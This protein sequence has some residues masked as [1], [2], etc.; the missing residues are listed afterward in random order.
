MSVG[1]KRICVPPRM[2]HAVLHVRRGWSCLAYV[3][4]GGA[5]ADTAEGA[6]A[7]L[8]ARRK[9]AEEEQRRCQAPAAA[10]PAHHGRQASQAAAAP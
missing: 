7:R 5:W 1:G 10:G 9:A 3:G 4:K 2:L 6:L 8:E